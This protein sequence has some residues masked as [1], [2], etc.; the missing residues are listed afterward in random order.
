V[1]T[2]LHFQPENTGRYL[3]RVVSISCK[4]YPLTSTKGCKQSLHD[5]FSGGVKCHEACASSM[6]FCASHYHIIFVHEGKLRSS[7]QL[8][9]LVLQH[10]KFVKLL[11]AVQML[12]LATDIM[13]AVIYCAGYFAVKAIILPFIHSIKLELSRVRDYA[14]L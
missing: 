8:L 11:I 14:V 7:T 6:V 3:Q 1:K 9:S 12:V 5:S 10:K 4:S 13:L 2:T